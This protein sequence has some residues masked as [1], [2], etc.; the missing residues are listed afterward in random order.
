MPRSP[1]PEPSEDFLVFFQSGITDVQKF[2]FPFKCRNVV[3][4]RLKMRYYSLQ[5]NTSIRNN[6]NTD[7]PVSNSVVL[8]LFIRCISEYHPV[9]KTKKKC[10]NQPV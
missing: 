7:N 1:P 9:V 2:F 3:Y 8:T 6:M 4:E 5:N 10:Q